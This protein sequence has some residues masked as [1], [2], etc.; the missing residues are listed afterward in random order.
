MKGREETRCLDSV[1]TVVKDNDRCTQYL[2]I[3][4]T[5]TWLLSSYNR[6]NAFV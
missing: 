4:V 3:H 2:L 5:V 1:W 6:T